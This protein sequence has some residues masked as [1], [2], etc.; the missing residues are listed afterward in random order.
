[1]ITTA[2]L[3][4]PTD[5]FEYPPPPGERFGRRVI[6]FA[7]TRGT[8]ERY[9]ADAVERCIFRP[10]KSGAPYVV[11]L[12]DIRFET[13]D[14]EGEVAPLPERDL[15]DD[16]AALARRARELLDVVGDLRLG[17]RE[18]PT[19]AAVSAVLA[20]ADALRALLDEH[21]A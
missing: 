14:T 6:L 16:Y 21:G 11:E 9:S 3:P 12:E 20:E 19:P 7:G 4:K 18:P 13:R 10:A 8:V 2:I 5:A 17:R 15:A 1:M